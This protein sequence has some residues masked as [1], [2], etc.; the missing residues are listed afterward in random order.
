MRKSADAGGRDRRDAIQGY[1]RREEYLTRL[2]G[3][4]DKTLPRTSIHGEPLWHVGTW[5]AVAVVLF[6]GTIAGSASSIVVIRKPDRVVLAADSKPTYHGMQGGQVVCKIYQVGDIFF[7]VGGLSYD[8]ERQFSPDTLVAQAIHGNGKFEWTLERSETA[9]ADALSAELQSLSEQSPDE[10]N[11]A[12]NY[13]P[14]VSLYFATAEAGVPRV[15]VRLFS[16]EHKPPFRVSVKRIDCPGMGC[17]SGVGAWWLGKLRLPERVPNW[18]AHPE[19]AARSYLAQEMKAQPYG[20]GPPFQI[21]R[22]TRRGYRWINNSGVCPATP[23]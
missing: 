14:V 9:I 8:R 10:L 11:F 5:L 15:A 2:A 16:A 19:R 7:S 13:D 22:I 12:L 17:P 23:R 21:L 20:V 18:S 3:F 6:T 1:P 4:P